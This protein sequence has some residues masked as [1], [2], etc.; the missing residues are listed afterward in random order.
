MVAFSQR[1]LYQLRREIERK[2]N[3]KCAII[4]GGLPPGAVLVL[5]KKNIF[6]VLEV[7]WPSDLGAGLTFRRSQ[8]QVVPSDHWMDL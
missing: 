2:S 3:W 8:V 6:E 5:T 7:V 1:D 4:Y